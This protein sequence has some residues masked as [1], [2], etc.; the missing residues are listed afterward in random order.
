MKILRHNSC[1]KNSL[2]WPFFTFQY[3]FLVLGRQLQTNW[4]RYML[5]VLPQE[6]GTS[7]GLLKFA[8]VWQILAD[9]GRYLIYDAKFLSKPPVWCWWFGAGSFLYANTLKIKIHGCSL[10][11]MYFWLSGYTY[12]R[13]ISVPLDRIWRC[14]AIGTRTGWN[15]DYIWYSY[16]DFG[17]GYPIGKTRRIWILFRRKKMC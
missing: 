17:T 11:L 4:Q 5:Q 14:I 6:L 1:Y 8:E 13:T 12:Q 2:F 15:H 7:V 10:V 9:I 3:G 16:L